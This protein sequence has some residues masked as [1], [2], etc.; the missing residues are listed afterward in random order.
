MDFQQRTDLLRQYLGFE[1]LLVLGL[2]IALAFSFY[3]L[4]LREANQDR[5][6]NIREYLREIY[7]NYFFV[8][9]LV[10]A[11]FG[12]EQHILDDSPLQRPLPYLAILTALW[13]GWVLVR[14]CRLLLL[15]YLFLGSMKAGVPVLLVNIF[16]LAMSITLLLWGLNSFFSVQ[17]GPLL[18]TSAVFSIVLGLAMQDTLGNLF[19]GISLQLDRAFE[20]D[21]WIEVASASQK[22]VGQV[23]EISWRSTTLIGWS[24]EVITIPNRVLAAAQISNFQNGEATFIRSQVFRLSYDVDPKKVQQILL[25]SIRPLTE[26]QPVPAPLCFVSETTDSW[27]S[28]KLVYAINRYGAQFLIGDKVLNSGWAALMRDGYSPQV[29]NLRVHSITEK[30]LSDRL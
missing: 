8:A 7:K 13:G 9:V 22:V 14:T 10:F 16:S 29:Q 26:I 11:M 23:H 25:D 30:P 19:A 20:I 24:D 12:L 1:A 5:H 6:E 28:F 15:M 27:M 4:L 18:A 17:L 3:K 21:D 2:M